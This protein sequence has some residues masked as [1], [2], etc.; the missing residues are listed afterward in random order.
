M[1]MQDMQLSKL[2]GSQ[3]VP[4]LPEKSSGE[5]NSARTTTWWQFGEKAAGVST[6]G[7]GR[8]GARKG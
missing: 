6:L 7:F 8:N 2:D 4:L 5:A 3:S 1:D